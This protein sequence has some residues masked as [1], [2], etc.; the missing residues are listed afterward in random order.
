MGIYIQC[1]A[2][3]Q[4]EPS[5]IAAKTIASSKAWATKYGLADMFFGTTD[6]AG[7]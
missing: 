7:A 1:F 3:C 4:G 2:D 6:D 5:D